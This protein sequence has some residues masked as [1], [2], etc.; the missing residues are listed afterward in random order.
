MCSTSKKRKNSCESCEIEKDT[1]GL[2]KT[3]DTTKRKYLKKKLKGSKNK[4]QESKE[5]LLN[6]VDSINAKE[7]EKRE[8]KLRKEVRIH[9]QS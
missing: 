6:L 8:E 5:E 9:F 2:I 7:D 1:D 3:T 4:L